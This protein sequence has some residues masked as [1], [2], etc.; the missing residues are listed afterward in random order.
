MAALFVCA[1]GLEA[2]AQDM[3]EMTY[4]PRE[5]VFKLHAPTNAKRRAGR[6]ALANLANETRRQ[7]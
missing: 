2:R 7:R 6:A 5:T 4:S 3:N 1:Q